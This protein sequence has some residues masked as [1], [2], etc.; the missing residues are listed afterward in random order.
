VL[1]DCTVHVDR[2]GQHHI[3]RIVTDCD[4]RGCTREEVLGGIVL[5]E[6]VGALESH[7]YDGSSVVSRGIFLSC[8]AAK[9]YS[10]NAN[11]PLITPPENVMRVVE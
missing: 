8:M 7:Q 5:A 6:V 10:V 1:V 11:G 4:V 9:G 3:T 2:L